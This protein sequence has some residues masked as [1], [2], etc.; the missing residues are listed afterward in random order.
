MQNFWGVSKVFY[1]RCKNGEYVNNFVN[2]ICFNFFLIYYTSKCAIIIWQD[3]F[4]SV[5]V[6]ELLCA[7]VF[8]F[9]EFEINLLYSQLSLNKHLTDNPQLL[10]PVIVQPFDCN[11]ALCKTETSQR[12]TTD[13]FETINGQLRSALGSGKYRKTE[14]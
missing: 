6:H 11:Y 10:A 14:M 2:Y 9:N 8:L 1:G 3:F 7:I 13:T 4:R 12:R 5:S